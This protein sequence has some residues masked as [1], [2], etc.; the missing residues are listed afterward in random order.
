MATLLTDLCENKTGQVHLF[1]HSMGSLALVSAL[2]RFKDKQ[3]ASFEN[4]ILAA[5]DLDADSF[6]NKLWPD[7]KQLAKQWSVYFSSRDLALIASR[8]INSKPRLGAN[9][10][11]IKGLEFIDASSVQLE[12]SGWLGS[13]NYYKQGSKITRDILEL[14]KGVKPR[15]R[16]LIPHEN[17]STDV[18]RFAD[19]VSI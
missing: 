15:H 16:A 11:P 7:I 13:H 8:Y 18:W 6:V 17:N 5:P 2:Q 14:I 9:A 19:S 3:Y 10:Y 1:A 4:V 12:Q